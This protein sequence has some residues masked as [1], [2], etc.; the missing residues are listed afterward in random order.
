MIIKKITIQ[1]YK[2]PF[3]SKTFL[4]KESF[5]FRKGWYIKICSEDYFG[6]GEAAPVPNISLENHIETG[7]ALEGFMVALEGIDYDIS[8]EELLL[9]SNVHG[10]KVPSVKFA[11]QSAVFD[12]YSK[13]KG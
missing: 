8:I 1:E 3:I 9:L 4:G 11:I 6:I 13:S 5:S 2:N 12:L 10:Y 7:Y